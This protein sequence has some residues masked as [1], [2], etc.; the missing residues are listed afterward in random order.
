M[1]NRPTRHEKS[2]E[3]GSAS[4]ERPSSIVQFPGRRKAAPPSDDFF[5]TE[6]SARSTGEPIADP[7]KLELLT[8]EKI[9]LG[10]AVLVAIIMLGALLLLLISWPPS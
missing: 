2:S 10:F 7:P 9:L 1:P 8:P 3:K 4:D 6:E 5:G